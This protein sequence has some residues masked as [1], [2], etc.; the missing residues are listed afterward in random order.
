MA[1]SGGKWC[2]GHGVVGHAESL[3]NGHYVEVYLVPYNFSVHNS[4]RGKGLAPTREPRCD[5][6]RS[7]KRWHDHHA[8]A[9]RRASLFRREHAVRWVRHGR[10]E[11]ID[12]ALAEMDVGGLTLEAITQLILDAIG[13]E[14]PGFCAYEENGRIVQ[15][16]IE[17]V[18][19][20]HVDVRNP[21]EPL[22]LENIGILCISCNTSKKK[23]RWHTWVYQRRAQLRAWEGAL[24]DPAFRGAEQRRLFDL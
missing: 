14:C 18:A 9:R 21:D 16:T 4:A 2:L 8:N 3:R 23:Q 7:I 20:M 19:D 12:A 5:H 22:S 10:C 13:E 11:T 15:H 17:R 1:F 24:N 6:C